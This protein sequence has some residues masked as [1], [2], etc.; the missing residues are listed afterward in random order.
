MTDARFNVATLRER[1]LETDM[2]AGF[3]GLRKRGETKVE[4]LQQI[5]SLRNNKPRFWW[6]EWE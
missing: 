6:T 2:C 4:D 1:N 5:F 3:K